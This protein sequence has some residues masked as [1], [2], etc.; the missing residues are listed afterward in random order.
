M[1]YR[2]SQDMRDFARLYKE[3][4][5]MYHI[6]AVRSGLS[7]SAFIIF[8]AMIELGEG[9]LQK[10]ISNQ[11]HISPQTINSSVRSLEKKGYIYLEPG[12]RRDMHIYLTESGRQILE[13][14]LGPVVEFENGVF[15]AMPPDER[16]QLLHLT[17]KYIDLYRKK[18]NTFSSED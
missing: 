4:E 3:L 2:Q 15:N 12:K 1:R 8:Y 14:R 17:R 11:Y 5:E 7:D 6:L 10:E 16:R 13:Q 9:C 18:L